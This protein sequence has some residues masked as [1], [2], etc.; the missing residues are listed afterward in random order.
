[1]IKEWI[2]EYAPK[3]IADAEQALREIM[4]EIALAGFQRNGFFERAAFYGG[5]ALRI[6]Y[7]LDRFSG[8]LDFSLITANPGFSIAPYLEGV[9]REF[10]ALG[11][12]IAINEKDKTKKNAIDSAFL[13]ADTIWKELLLKDI[14]GEE[15]I[16]LRPDIKIKL[17]V[18]TNP[19]LGFST[20]D[21]LLLRPFS[22]YTKCYTL[23]DLFAGKMHALLFRKWKNRVKGRDWYDFEWYIRRVTPLHLS[24]FL[25]RAQDSEDW[26]V[27]AITATQFMD[28]LHQRINALSIER[29]K[30]DVRPFVKDAKRLDIWSKAY[31]HDLADKL[32]I[33]LN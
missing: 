17:E 9:Q 20:E 31:F 1:M 18:D 16:G 22:F 32:I 13:K 7:N 14:I 4:Q 6:F 15:K 2:E 26:T 33:D 29:A 23:P 25:R 11:I 19:P 24:H 8:D 27:D 28:L 12:K 5:T 21:K 3:N 30:E 10:E